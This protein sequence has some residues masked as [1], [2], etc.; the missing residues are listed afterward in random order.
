L[1][2]TCVADQNKSTILLKKETRELLS[3]IGRKEQ[4]YD[5]LIRELI[6]SK[7]KLDSLE[8]RSAVLDS[9]ESTTTNH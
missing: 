6:Q 3:K 4:T 1:L 7:N 5:Q 2:Y 9:G 8:S